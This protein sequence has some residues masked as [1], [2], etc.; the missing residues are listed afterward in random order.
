MRSWMNSAKWQYVSNMK[1]DM[2]EIRILDSTWFLDVLEKYSWEIV[3]GIIRIREMKNGKIVWK[4]KRKINE[5]ISLFGLANCRAMRGMSR[6]EICRQRNLRN[7][8]EYFETKKKRE[9]FS[10]IL[11]IWMIFVNYP[12]EYHWKLGGKTCSFI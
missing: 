7:S 12:G 4:N 5:T 8:V 2:W 9:Y 11:S 6:L 10:L 1:S 3:L